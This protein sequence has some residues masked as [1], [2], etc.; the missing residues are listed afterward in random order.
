LSTFKDCPSK[1]ERNYILKE[2][3]PR[4]SAPAAERGT[5]IH[6]SIEQYFLGNIE[7]TQ[8]DPEIDGAYYE[9]FEQLKEAGAEPEHEFGFDHDFNLVPYDDPTANL[10]G[11]I[12]LRLKAKKALYWDWKTGKKNDSHY[13]QKA[14]YGLATLLEPEV[15]TA[16]GEM[17]YLDLVDT[18]N[19]IT[20]TS[21]MLRSYK[22]LWAKRTEVV[23]MATE[24]PMRPSWKCGWCPFSRPNGGSCPHG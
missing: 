5:R 24:F 11:K 22:F 12:D 21:E 9:W 20:Y 15:E 2:E 14:L 18:S 23:R 13:D 19:A 16:V 3:V 6:D 10:R 8:L 4:M 1:F 17:V 7:L